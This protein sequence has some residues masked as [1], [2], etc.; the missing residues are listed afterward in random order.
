MPPQFD[1]DPNIVAIRDLREENAR[2]QLGGRLTMAEW[3]AV[4]TALAQCL[5]GPL[6]GYSE[7]ESQYVQSQMRNALDKIQALV[8]R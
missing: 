4:R 3:R 5:A 7:R 1:E 8:R 2:L 6:D